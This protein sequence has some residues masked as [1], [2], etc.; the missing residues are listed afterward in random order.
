MAAATVASISAIIA[1]DAR[2]RTVENRL[3]ITGGLQTSR[4]V[5]IP[6]EPGSIQEYSS[7]LTEAGQ[8]FCKGDSELNYEIPCSAPV[9]LYLYYD[10]NHEDTPDTI[11]DIYTHYSQ[12]V[13]SPLIENEDYFD[14]V[15]GGETVRMFRVLGS[16]DRSSVYF[17]DTLQRF[18]M[19]VD[20]PVESALFLQARPD[21]DEPDT[22]T[23]YGYSLCHTDA[24]SASSPADPVADPVADPDLLA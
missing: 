3:G 16:Y 10:I 18:T 6:R 8:I 22:W 23:H 17:T 5:A 4:P 12:L 19:A 7:F 11:K 20:K 9:A 24:P 1:L 14:L 21:P 2:V 13:P 15:S